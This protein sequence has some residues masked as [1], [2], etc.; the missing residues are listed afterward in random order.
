MMERPPCASPFIRETTWKQEALSRPLQASGYREMLWTRH[1]PGP[2]DVGR[3]CP[4]RQALWEALS[5]GCA[6]NGGTHTAGRV[7]G[8]STMGLGSSTSPGSA[9]GWHHSPVLQALLGWLWGPAG[10][11]ATLAGVSQDK[12]GTFHRDTA[13][14]AP[15]RLLWMPHRCQG[16]L[17][18]PHP[19][20]PGFA[21]GA[22]GLVC[23]DR[24]GATP[25]MAVQPH[26]RDGGSDASNV[27]AST[28]TR[29]GPPV[30]HGGFRMQEM[31]MAPGCSWRA[32]P[33]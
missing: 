15:C 7:G 11:R 21:M 8:F 5:G 24:P 10:A 33:P 16:G 26:C 4:R 28:A 9:K 23:E 17:F 25:P 14:H 12:C 22:R 3:L 31:I 20:L 30:G 32:S 2:G 1:S 27:E 13:S 19:Q 29:A 18:L 6:L